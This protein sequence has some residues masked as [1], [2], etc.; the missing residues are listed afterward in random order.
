MKISGSM[1]RVT[2]DVGM[3]ATAEGEAF[4]YS[5]LLAEMQASTTDVLGSDAQAGSL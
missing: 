2:G 1:D 3:V 4:D 5:R